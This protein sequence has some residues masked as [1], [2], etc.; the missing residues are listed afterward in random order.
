MNTVGVMV[1][2]C[3]SPKVNPNPHSTIIPKESAVANVVA[4]CINNNHALP[5][6]YWKETNDN[7]TDS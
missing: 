6:H 4:G 5:V 2:V 7:S 3:N 1:G